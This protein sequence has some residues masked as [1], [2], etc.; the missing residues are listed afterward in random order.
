VPRFPFL[1]IAKLALIFCYVLLSHRPFANFH[2]DPS[3]V[4]SICHSDSS[5]Y[6]IAYSFSESPCSASSSLRGSAFVITR[7]YDALGFRSMQDSVKRLS[8]FWLVSP[9]PD[10]FKFDSIRVHR[11]GCPKSLTYWSL[12]S[13]APCTTCLTLSCLRSIQ[14][15]VPRSGLS[16]WQDHSTLLL[17]MK[18]RPTICRG[19]TKSEE[20]V[21]VKS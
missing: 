20:S 7:Y 10:L 6:L 3:P 12:T 18:C 16:Q 9:F 14:C 13:K 17:Y 21:V 2:F 5:Y 4:I 19:K 15:S 11:G 1:Y 8:L